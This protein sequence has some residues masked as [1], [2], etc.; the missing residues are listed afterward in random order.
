MNLPSNLLLPAL[1]EVA[2]R[3][4][5]TA[6]WQGGGFCP[7]FA[8]CKLVLC[9]HCDQHVSAVRRLRLHIRLDAL[10]FWEAWKRGGCVAEK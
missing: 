4:Q 8:V 6:G 2:R 5:R 10:C 1:A 9:A 3:V 7:S